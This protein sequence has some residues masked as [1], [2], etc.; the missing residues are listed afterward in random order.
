MCIRMGTRCS[1][2]RLGGFEFDCVGNI[3]VDKIWT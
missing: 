2:A 1:V 3:G